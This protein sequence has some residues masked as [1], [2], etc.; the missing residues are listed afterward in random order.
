MVVLTI[1]QSY[2]FPTAPME[3]MDFRQK[4]RP[5]STATLALAIRGT[6]LI[7][8][9]NQ[10]FTRGPSNPFP[11]H[12]LNTANQSTRVAS[13]M[14]HIS[15]SRMDPKDGPKIRNEE[16]RQFIRKCVE[17]Y[18]RYLYPL[19]VFGDF[20]KHIRTDIL[21]SMKPVRFLGDSLKCLRDF[22]ED[23]RH[24]AGYQLDKVQ[25]GE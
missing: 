15:K 6:V 13:Q 16:G 21:R 18:N 11:C 9:E 10:H 12:S 4:N 2:W 19:Q 20:A 23:A 1:F 17:K 5:I 3:V 24:D 14:R 7:D 8:K 25:R 22:P